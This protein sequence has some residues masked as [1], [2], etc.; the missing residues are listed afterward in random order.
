VNAG[1]PPGAGRPRTAP[2]F[3]KSTSQLRVLL[4]AR[5]VGFFAHGVDVGGRMRRGGGFSVLMPFADHVDLARCSSC[6]FDQA[7]PR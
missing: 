1:P 4:T 2:Q 5:S 6:A 3:P 7:C